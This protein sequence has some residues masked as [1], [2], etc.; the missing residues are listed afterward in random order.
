MSTKL[1]SFWGTLSPGAPPLDPAGGHPSRRPPAFT[2]SAT[3]DF[4]PPPLLLWLQQFVVLPDRKSAKLRR[5]HRWLYKS[6]WDSSRSV[7]HEDQF[8][9]QV[10]FIV[11]RQ[12]LHSSYACSSWPSSS[13]FVGRA[14]FLVRYCSVVRHSDLQLFDGC[15]QVVFLQ[16][17]YSSWLHVCWVYRDRRTYF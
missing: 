13:R 15:T 14:R 6:V 5:D 7:S 2:P 17:K 3:S 8:Q 9:R 10:W 11:E 4:V 16:R 1:F 12:W